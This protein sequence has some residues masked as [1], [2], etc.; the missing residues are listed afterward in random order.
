MK[1]TR[2]CIRGVRNP[3]QPISSP[4]ALMS[5]VRG[6]GDQRNQGQS[7]R[8]REDRR[9][10]GLCELLYDLASTERVECEPYVQVREQT[11]DDCHAVRDQVVACLSPPHPSPRRVPSR[12]SFV[13]SA[14]S[15]GHHM[16]GR[17]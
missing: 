8:A 2:P 14:A 9:Q 3:L 16:N 7:F 4:A 10:P 12:S 15:P 6:G 17:A 1:P 13:T 5:P 11:D